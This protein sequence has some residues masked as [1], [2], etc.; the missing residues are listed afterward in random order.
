MQLEGREFWN[1]GSDELHP[2]K[3]NA[4]SVWLHVGNIFCPFCQYKLCNLKYR[5]L[6]GT[7]K[8]GTYLESRQEVYGCLKCGWWSYEYTRGSELTII[9]EFAIG[10]ILRPEDA[11]L[12]APVPIIREYLNKHPK[13]LKD[14]NPISLE[15][16]LKDVF[17]DYFDCEVKWTGRGPDGGFDLYHVL[18][19]SG[20]T[21]YQIKRRGLK[22]KNEGV[23]PLRALVGA[24]LEEKVTTG[25]F[26]T[27]ADEFTVPAKEY[28]S[29]IVERG[30]K[31]ELIDYSKLMDVLKNTLPKNIAPWRHLWNE[32]SSIYSNYRQNIKNR[33]R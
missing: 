22:A 23:V 10:C 19:D 24:M 3:E 20:A 7:D 16:V 25:I 18:T 9:T 2:E 4:E 29:K 28:T 32:H 31:I 12:W 5:E 33:E 15:Q 8:E 27:T 21:L 1:D 17:S 11:K 30:F 6:K 13:Y 14:I 26:V